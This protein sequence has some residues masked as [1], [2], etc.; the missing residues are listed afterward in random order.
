MN[1]VEREKVIMG[2]MIAI[3]CRSHHNERSADGLC[4][5]CSELLAYARQCIGRCPKGDSKTSCRK[6]E[7]HCYSAINRAKVRDVM[8]YVGPRML[9]RHPIAALW[10]LYSELR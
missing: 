3:Y 7:I 9:Y 10:H 1:R 4:G 5:E 8:R 6:C 2:Q